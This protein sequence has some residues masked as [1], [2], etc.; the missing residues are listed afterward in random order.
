MQRPVWI[1]LFII[2]LLAVALRFYQLGRAPLW[3]DE[4]LQFAVAAQPTL[5][6]VLSTAP[7]KGPV[8]PVG[9]VCDSIALRLFGA[10][11]SS[12][13][14]SSALF[15]VGSVV[16]IFFLG[17]RWFSTGTGLFAAAML[18]VSGLAVQFSREARP[19]SALVFAAL[20]L[21]LTFD[22]AVRPRETSPSMRAPRLLLLVLSSMFICL[23][24]PLALVVFAGLGL[25]TA[26]SLFAKASEEATFKSALAGAL[27]FLAG[28]GMA[29]AFWWRLVPNVPF[30]PP[31]STHSLLFDLIDI[32]KALLGGY[33][34]AASY[35]VALALAFS[36][37]AAVREK[38]WRWGFCLCAG[39]ALL[40]LAPILASHARSM[41]VLPRY[42]LFA[43]P[44]L[45][46]LAGAGFDHAL[47][48]MARCG[49]DRARGDRLVAIAAPGLCGILL[50][51]MILSG[52]SIYDLEAK[53][54]SSDRYPTLEQP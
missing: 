8:G 36:T 15:G 16:A 18:A 33:W 29:Y 50:I 24:H 6:G 25:G 20:L 34:G 30:M 19:Y 21:A 3:L 42:S 5:G 10:A 45:F 7:D 14:V 51:C 2:V 12:M 54:Y 1:S 23:V 47:R 39:V 28:G 37:V 48:W 11:R 32:Y 52:R 27:A 43:M 41:N 22:F 17:Q 40:G 49:A 13:R 38:T 46:L 26:V 35:A 44:F 9:F 53:K 31:E 4:Q